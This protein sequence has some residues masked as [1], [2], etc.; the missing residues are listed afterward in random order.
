MA[1]TTAEFAIG[2]TA[3]LEANGV[4]LTDEAAFA[5]DVAALFGDW[6]DQSSEGFPSAGLA[7]RVATLL[8]NWNA[9]Q[10]QFR[11]W[12][13][14]EPDGGWTQD[15]V[16]PGGGYYPLT[17][18]LGNI[19]Y[20]PS[21]AK[22]LSD[23]A[24][25]Y[26]ALEVLVDAGILP[27][28]TTEAQFADWLRAPAVD[29]VASLQAGWQTAYDA[30]VI[31]ADTAEDALALANA[32]QDAADAALVLAQETVDD[33]EAAALQATGAAD[34]AAAS[35]AAIGTAEAD[36]EAARDEAVLA[37]NAA[38][39]SADG[40]AL[41]EF[42]AAGSAGAAASSATEASAD[43]AA[44]DLDR[45]AAEAAA[46]AALASEQDAEAAAIAADAS[47]LAALNS[48]NDAAA[49][50]IASAASAAAAL[51][52]ETAADA[53]ELGAQSSEDDAE[54]ALALAL[55]AQAAAE[56]ARDDAETAAGLVDAPLIEA[57]LDALEDR[58]VGFEIVVD[59]AIAGGNAIGLPIPGLTLDRLLVFVNY[60]A[61]KS[62]SVLVGQTLTVQAEA[63][64]VIAVV[65]PGGVQGR[66]G[67]DRIVD[68]SG[69]KAD[70]GTYD[71][72]AAGFVYQANDTLEA[73]A[74]L[75]AVAGD[76]G[77]WIPLTAGPEGP[78]G[79]DA[80]VTAG[81]IATALGFTPPALTAAAPV[82]LRNHPSG[83]VGNGSTAA[84]WNH[85]H[86][87]PLATGRVLAGPGAL[88]ITDH[89]TVVDWDAA[90]GNI[91][92][93]DDLTAGFN[94]LVCVAHET[95]RPTFVTSGGA[96]IRQADGLATAR[97]QWS[98]IS[99]RVRSN[100]GAA[101]EWVLSGDLA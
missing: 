16:T 4:N 99:V 21:P 97:A 49:E 40:A 76:W 43:A 23:L 95:G 25:G 72:E 75:S 80:A 29:A 74:K 101:A 90:N 28:G 94:C 2:L 65:L 87:F 3:L 88:A 66:D 14:G 100:P 34:A 56:A 57:R 27:G 92:L 17:D 37:R 73:S 52:S 84:R 6:T 93:P 53:S 36:T 39:A 22:M 26:S 58:Q 5:T 48:A 68:A 13:V 69:L 79:D 89:G 50:A 35:L 38:V 98:E 91:T 78:P 20:L 67:A 51:A 32:A 82:A 31:A 18:G 12:W 70:R 11:A 85:E 10:V 24:R 46:A 47:A 71:A 42:N 81:N 1:I 30:A 77:P 54:A 86:A 45:I 64:D 15:G 7:L 60:L 44:A 59:P 96:V 19:R 33:A 61:D 55:A 8:A 62:G 41:S 9:N 63:G 83:A